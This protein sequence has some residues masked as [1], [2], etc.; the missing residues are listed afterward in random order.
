MTCP[1]AMHLRT[2]APWHPGTLAPWHSGTSAPRHLAP[3][4][5]RPIERDEIHRLPRRRTHLTQHR[6]HLPAVVARM[7]DDV[8]QHLPEGRRARLAVDQRVLEDARDARVAEAIDKAAHLRFVL[9]P[10]RAQARDVRKHVRR[11]QRRR[12]CFLTRSE[13]HTS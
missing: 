8:L 11:R 3:S 4:L 7:V 12:T 13:E 9:R 2:V 5:A 1:W 10:R 6:R